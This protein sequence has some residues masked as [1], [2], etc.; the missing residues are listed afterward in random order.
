M[1]SL[2]R[3]DLRLL[4]NGFTLTT[5]SADTKTSTIKKPN[6]NNISFST[7]MAHKKEE[8]AFQAKV[9]E[10]NIM[11]D[12]L[13]WNVDFQPAS[14]CTFKQK[15]ISRP[16]SYHYG[17]PSSEVRTSRLTSFLTFLGTIFN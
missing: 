5:T 3:E 9:N 7:Q 8:S 6:N 12:A 4:I 13:R 17:L 16:Y 10:L 11:N 15:A 2:S 1:I 14:N